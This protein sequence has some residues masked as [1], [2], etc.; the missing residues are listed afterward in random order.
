LLDGLL[1]HNAGKLLVGE[2]VIPTRLESECGNP[3][4]FFKVDGDWFRKCYEI[5]MF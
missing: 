5:D 3:G 4:A 2:H 1:L